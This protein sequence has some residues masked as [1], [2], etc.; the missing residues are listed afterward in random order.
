MVAGGLTSRGRGAGGEGRRGVGRGLPGA[1]AQVAALVLLALCAVLVAPAAAS[2]DEAQDAGITVNLHDYTA[3]AVNY[4][5]GG[6]PWERVMHA[7]RFGDGDKTNDS[8]NRWTNS[9]AVLSGILQDTLVNGYPALSTGR[10]SDSQLDGESL[11]YLFNPQDTSQSG[12][13]HHADVS[14]LL[15]QDA[16]GYWYYSANDNYA[17]FNGSSFQLYDYPRFNIDQ[18]NNGNDLTGDQGQ[19]MPFNRLSDSQSVQ[20]NGK[21]GYSL[22]GEANYHFGIDVSTDFIYP[23]D[24]QVNGQDMVFEFAGDDDVWVFIDGT[25]VLDLGGIHNSAT[26]TINFATGDVTVNGSVVGNLAS[27]LGEGWDTAYQEHTMNFYY[28]ERGE[29]SSNMSIRFNLPTIPSGTI[30]VGKS[31]DYSN[32]NDVS[33]IDFTFNAYVNADGA[34]ED[35]QLYTGSYGVYDM[36]TNA[37]LETRTATDGAIVFKDGQYARLSDGITEAS[38]Y[39]LVEVGATSDK[40]EVDITNADIE[41]TQGDGS[42]STQSGATTDVISVVDNAYVVFGNSIVADNA[43]NLRVQKTGSVPEEET[44]YARVQV[45]SLDYVGEYAVYDAGGSEVR[46]ASTSN[47]VIELKTGQYAEIAGLAG[48]NTVSVYEVTPSGDA[49]LGQE[50]YQNPSYSMAGS[51]L[52][53]GATQ[54][55]DGSGNVVG[56]SGTAAEGRELGSQPLITATIENALTTGSLSVSKEVTADEGL[57]AP[58]GTFEFEVHIDGLGGSVPY[59]LTSADGT[60][61]E[62]RAQF[63]EG[64]AMIELTDGQTATF[65]G[66]AD[67]TTWSVTEKNVPA[68][69]EN[70]SED[71][72]PSGTVTAGEASSASFTNRYVGFG[73]DIYKGAATGSGSDVTADPETPLQGAEFTLYADDGSTVV[74]TGVTGDDGHVVLSGLGDGTYYLEETAAPAGYELLGQ[75]IAVVVSNGQATLTLGDSSRTVEPNEE[76]NFELSVADEETPVLP[77]AGGSGVT[78]LYAAGAATAAGGAALVARA[79]R[80]RRA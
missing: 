38:A 15:R 53:S 14:G 18:V 6:R 11:A 67:G 72:A 16:D 66:I 50:G 51:A 61:S 21:W 17:Y 37:L 35:F 54:V 31:V 3:D 10:L 62:Q 57:T 55:T 64:D 76:G 71:Q 73:L 30:N 12:V 33:D 5:A 23:R 79:M 48:G 80:R 58:S 74:A 47:G 70:V 32:V 42:S 60:T 77:Q 29:G 46:T 69:F 44:F 78:P 2:A 39:Y 7:L 9:E 41:V 25:L 34:G 45:G 26:G 19:F 20:G 63:T 65:E 13:T 24:G 8:V 27:L 36:D 56:V 4:E 40:Y 68:G 1:L 22:E 49:F 43:F 52:A 59:T 28:L 75:R